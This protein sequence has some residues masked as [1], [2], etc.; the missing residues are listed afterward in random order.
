MVGRI[1]LRVF[2]N[3][4]LQTYLQG[5]QDEIILLTQKTKS[6]FTE[7]KVTDKLKYTELLLNKHGQSINPELCHF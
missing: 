7:K 2:M 3:H 6:L 5:K 4:L 1:F